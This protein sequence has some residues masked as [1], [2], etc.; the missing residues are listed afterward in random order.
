MSRSR[1]ILCALAILFCA[2]YAHAQL[3]DA[4]IAA[5]IDISNHAPFEKETFVIMLTIVTRGIEIRQQLDLANL[6]DA[7]QIAIL[8]G[9]APLPVERQVEGL[10]T[11]ETRRYR[12]RARGLMTGPVSFSPLL[13]LTTRRRVRSF[14]GSAVEEHPVRIDIPPVTIDIRPLPPPPPL[15]CGAIGNFA[16]DISANP[17]HLVAGDLITLTTQIRGEGYL[18]N[19]RIPGVAS[20]PM[21]KTYPVKEVQHAPRVRRFAQIVIPESEQITTIPPLQITWFDTASGQ[22][23]NHHAGPFALHYRESRMRVVEHFRPG[24]PSAASP[25]RPLTGTRAR[26]VVTVAKP[27]SAA[28]LA[29]SFASRITFVLPTEAVRVLEYHGDWLLIEH[30]RNRGWIHDSVLTP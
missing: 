14:F 12:A 13:R 23:T 29:P 18:E 20:A 3:P 16:V 5:D 1:T 21:L 26:P 19:L 25:P 2:G 4:P 17:T 22:Y 11:I 28:R 24:D 8:D 10:T 7:R 30:N 27:D 9:F 15:F 6:P